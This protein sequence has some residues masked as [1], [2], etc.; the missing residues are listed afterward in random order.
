VAQSPSLQSANRDRILK[1]LELHGVIDKD[2]GMPGR[3]SSSAKAKRHAHF[4]C[5]IDLHGKTQLGAAAALRQ[6]ISQSGSRGLR[7]VL[8]IHGM[9]LR[10]DPA[11]GPVLR[12][13][14]R[15]MLDGELRHEIRDYAPAL[16]RDGGDGATVVRLR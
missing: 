12:N 9:G 6:F 2:A 5:S 4:D 1:H 13:L 16:P 11:D 7:R 15:Q 14:V 10:S 8:I 3:S